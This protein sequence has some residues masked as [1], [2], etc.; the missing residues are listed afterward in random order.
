MSNVIPLNKTSIDKSLE[1]FINSLSEI[2]IDFQF[3]ESEKAFVKAMGETSLLYM[4]CFLTGV[5]DASEKDIK[6]QLELG[7]QFKI[8]LIFVRYLIELISVK[9]LDIKMLAFQYCLYLKKKNK[10][11]SEQKVSEEVFDYF[12]RGSHYIRT[13][14]IDEDLEEEDSVAFMIQELDVKFLKS[15]SKESLDK[16]DNLAKRWNRNI[17]NWSSSDAIR[18]SGKHS[19]LDISNDLFDEYYLLHGLLEALMKDYSL[20]A[21]RYRQFVSFIM[22]SDLVKEFNEHVG[23]DVLFTMK[24]KD[25]K[26]SSDTFE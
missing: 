15:E 7:S 22:S 25:V 13:K 19:I 4:I 1:D 9:L 21:L 8:R 20:K 10:N 26:K 24:S 6:Q 11:I 18:G 5:A 3:N 23:D 16:V 2:E 12:E 17:K 14:E